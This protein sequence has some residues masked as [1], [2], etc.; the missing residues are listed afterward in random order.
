MISHFLK[1][2]YIYTGIFEYIYNRNMTIFISFKY[3]SSHICLDCRLL[4]VH[5]SSATV[6]LLAIYGVLHLH[7]VHAW[8]SLD[9]VPSATTPLPHLCLG[10]C[11]PLVLRPERLLSL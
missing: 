5:V 7:G 11:V 9:G 2:I 4:V 1:Y 10:L 3:P 6:R 8:G